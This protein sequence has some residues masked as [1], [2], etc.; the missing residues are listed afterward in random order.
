MVVILGLG[1][2]STMLNSLLA[3]SYKSDVMSIYIKGGQSSR[4]W[5]ETD[6]VD[7]VLKK[8]F[9]VGFGVSFDGLRADW[10]KFTSTSPGSRG[11]RVSLSY[12]FFAD[13]P[14]NI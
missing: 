11:S 7:T 4:V 5:G 2:I 3:A 14:V 6:E 9:D 1:L 12:D 8:R 13:R 10:S